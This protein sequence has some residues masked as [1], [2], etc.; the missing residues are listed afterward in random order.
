MSSEQDLH[1]F[2]REALAGGADRAEIARALSDAGWSPAQIREEM[3]RFTGS[4]LSGV[5]VP[6]PRP[7]SRARD[8]FVYGA[9]FTSLFVTAVNIGGILFGVIDVLLGVVDMSIAE[10]IRSPLSIAIVSTPV[11][12]LPDR[13]VHKDM[14]EDPN[15]RMSD[16]RRA[17]TYATLF[18]SG[19]VLLGVVSAL[20]YNVLGGE[21][22]TAFGLKSL[23]VGGIAG[24][25]FTHYLKDMQVERSLPPG[26]STPGAWV[27]DDTTSA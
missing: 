23:V 19:L 10:A 12:L 26:A 1:D 2:V 14:I 22:T 13:L 8:I 9:L 5:A 18:V 4:T 15:R 6:R 16:I 24:V 7:S 17:L 21:L 20:I 3:D 25:G 27:S 11:L